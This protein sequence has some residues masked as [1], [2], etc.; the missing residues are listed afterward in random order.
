M[1]L[2]TGANGQLGYDVIQELKR[3]SIECKGVDIDALDVTDEIET[4][5]YIIKLKPTCVI[6]CAA[7][8]MVDEAE[9]SEYKCNLIN[10]VGTENVMKACIA[11]N[12]KLMII[13]TDYIFDGEKIGCYE[14]DDVPNPISIYGK[15][16]YVAEQIVSKN[17]EKF[18]IIRTSWL[19]GNNGKN[20][21]RTILKISRERKKINVVDDQIGSP[22]YSY[23][24]ATRICDIIM[25]DKYGIYH[26]TNRGYCSWR[27]FAEKIIE[28]ANEECIVVGISSEEYNSLA[29]RPKNSKMSKKSLID[30]GFDELPHWEDAVGRYIGSILTREG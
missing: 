26:V 18:F 15:S 19:F 29:V 25:S 12:S 8:T 3:R 6:H 14:I 4:K 24:L 13:S 16:K 27:E 17:I 30:N 22:T 23:D 2:V 9:K 21:V 11:I 20:F 5:K 7:Y 1:I 28:I 10:I